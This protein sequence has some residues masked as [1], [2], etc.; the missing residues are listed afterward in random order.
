MEPY[1]LLEQRWAEWAHVDNVVACS[2]GTAA[3]HLALEALRLPPGS[4]VLVPDLTMVACARAVALAGLTPV[5][6]DCNNSL[7]MDPASAVLACSDNTSAIMAVHIYGRR[8]NMEALHTLARTRKLAVIEDL[9]E[10]H[11]VEPHKDSDASCWSFYRNKIVHGEEGGAV[12]FKDREAA[13]LARKLR[14]LGFTEKHDFMHIPRGHNYRLANV[15][16][17]LVLDSLAQADESIARRREIC[18]ELEAAC[19]QEWR[20][21]PRQVPWVYDLR[22]PCALDAVVAAVPGARHCFKPM[23]E[24][25]EFRGC[26][27]WSPH[28][29]ALSREVLY[30]PIMPKT[31]AKSAFDAIHRA[32]CRS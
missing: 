22:V 13:E 21:P 24:Q 23:S 25:P 31:D 20:M 32:M 19:P 9:A 27:A 3:L 1:K 6:V 29:T 30:L 4:E 10:A 8:C 15:L 26:R 12:A 2:S 16:A 18:F 17:S 14:C 7:L 28:A 11:G 5:F